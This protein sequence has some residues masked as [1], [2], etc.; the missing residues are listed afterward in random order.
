MLHLD[1]DRREEDCA[2]MFLLYRGNTANYSS[3]MGATYCEHQAMNVNLTC[4]HTH[5]HIHEKPQI[6]HICMGMPT[7][8]CDNHANH[9]KK[10]FIIQ[11][12]N[13]VQCMCAAVQY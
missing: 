1:K 4:T 13:G 6:S 5:T 10:T 7:G 3:S 9:A 2:M 12:L 8:M 11:I